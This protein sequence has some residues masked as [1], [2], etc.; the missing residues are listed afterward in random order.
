MNLIWLSWNQ[1]S[2]NKLVVSFFCFLIEPFRPSNHSRIS[3]IVILR[4]GHLVQLVEDT[5]LVKPYYQ[6]NDTRHKTEEA[7][8][9]SPAHVRLPAL[10]CLFS[11]E[12]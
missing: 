3:I 1:T 4:V 8:P 5:G 10:F 11:L 12:P 7:E 9:K 2:F 6:H